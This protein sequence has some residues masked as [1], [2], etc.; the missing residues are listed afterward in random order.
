MYPCLHFQD[1]LKDWEW[2]EK[3][4]LGT[5]GSFETAEEATEFVSIKIE[6]L[7]AANR[8]DHI[9]ESIEDSESL[10]YKTA[11]EKFHRLFNVGKEDKLVSS[12]LVHCHCSDHMHKALNLLFVSG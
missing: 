9:S 4:C 11:S 10:P 1:A 3:N 8:S 2:L 12:W 5:L 6:S 7:L